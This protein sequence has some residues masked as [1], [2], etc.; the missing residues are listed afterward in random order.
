MRVAVD[1]DG[2]LA[3][4]QSLYL[5]LLNYRHGAAVRLSEI[6]EWNAY[7]RLFGNC[8]LERVLDLVD[9]THLRRAIRP[10]SPVAPAFVKWLVG[11]GHAVE[12]LTSNSEVTAD[13]IR[14]WNFGHGL[15][16]PVRAIGRVSAA[17]KAAMDYDLF[18][19]DSPHIIEPVMDLGKF[20]MLV[21]AP[22]NRSVASLGYDGQPNFYRIVDWSRVFEAA[23]KWDL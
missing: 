18:M 7:D 12:V 10:T 2:T 20:L 16:V 15:D 23:R 5:A 19:D 13:S 22:Y 21:D 4:S 3:D 8:E 14:A 17:N 11:R 1:F 6:D 9:N